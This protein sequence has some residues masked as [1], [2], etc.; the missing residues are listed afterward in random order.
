[1]KKTSFIKIIFLSLLFAPIFSYAD[2]VI[3]N[4]LIVNGSQCIGQ[5]CINGETFDFSTIILK[6]NNL[7]IKFQDT[8]STSSFP[9]TDWQ[10]TI[11][12]SSNGGANYF[13]IDNLDLSQS[14]LKITHDGE[15]SM[16]KNSD[17]FVLSSSG[18][19]SILGTLSDSSDVN[20]KE[21]ILPVDNA[22]IL[23]KVSSLDISTWNY[24]ENSQK[25]RH[26]GAM[27]QDFYKAFAFGA[28]NK[29]IAPKDVAFVAVASVKELLKQI[30]IRDKKVKELEER[31]K[32]LEAMFAN[33]TTK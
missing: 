17:R 24:K 21:N 13:A 32:K 8:S 20:L 33:L 26:I 6:E 14:L 29:H 9:S 30:K 12:D 22:K 23:Q 5:D 16:G 1:M 27:A 10:I 19:L 11:N 18:D 25:S 2:E 7:R 15:V 3:L 4:D 28:D 31:L